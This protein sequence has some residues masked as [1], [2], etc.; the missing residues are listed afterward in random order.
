M[1]GLFIMMPKPKAVKSNNQNNQRQTNHSSEQVLFESQPNMILYS[2]NFILKIVVLFFLVFMFNPILALIFHFQGRLRSFYNIDIVNLT[3]IAELVLIFCIL[4]IIV[5]LALDILDWNNTR[6]TL[7]QKRIII[8]RGLLN[9]ETVTMPYSKVQDID[10]GQSFIDRIL[11]VGDIVIY[12]GHENS[13]T[14]LDAVPNPGEVEEI[15][16]EQMD[17]YQGGLSQYQQGYLPPNQQGYYPQNQ[18]GGYQQNYYNQNNYI[19]DNNYNPNYVQ[20]DTYGQN[21]YANNMPPRNNNRN[22]NSN[23]RQDNSNYRQDNSTY[24]QDNSNYRQDNN[25]TQE[26][27]YPDNNHR[28]NKHRN[29]NH[30]GNS[31][32]Y[33]QNNQSNYYKNNYNENK[34]NAHYYQNNEDN[35]I[36]N[37]DYTRVSEM[38]YNNSKLD[39]DELISINNRKFKKS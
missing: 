9:K 39:K 2:D 7:T 35:S 18:A 16:Y 14:I 37:R 25:H 36:K 32:N 29:K 13:E 33:R 31:N 12:G 30:K 19:N 11:G 6:Y 3:F 27:N 21:R 23:Y 22:N 15:I 5:K 10:I 1:G 38:E 4:I 20:E 34:S 28:Q 26:E 24:G 8:K 17:K